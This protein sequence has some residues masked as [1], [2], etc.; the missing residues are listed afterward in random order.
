MSKVLLPGDD[1]PVPKADL[2][3]ETP[4][5]DVPQQWEG[6]YLWNLAK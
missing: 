4:R 1:I 3:F 6:W 2:K 5:L